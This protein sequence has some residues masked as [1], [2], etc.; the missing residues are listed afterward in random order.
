M[1]PCKLVEVDTHEG[2]VYVEALDALF[3]TSVPVGG[4]GSMILR[5]S[6]RDRT[7]ERLDT[8]AVRPNGMTLDAGGRLVVCEQ[9]D[10]SNDACIS[11]I[12]PTTL[13][14][15]VLVDRWQ[16]RRLNSPN[17]VA[18][19]AGG[20]IWFTDPSY[21]FLQGFRPTP[22]LDDRV[23]RY[24]PGNG[25]VE[26]VADGFDKPN[27]IALA[28]DGSTLYVADSGADR[29]T[30]EFD[31]ARRHQVVAYDITS[32]NRLSGR[33]VF[34]VIERGAPDGL[35]VDVSGRVYVSSPAGVLVYAPD[36][37]LVG[38]IDVP[39]AVNFCFGRYGGNDVLFITADTAVWVA[40]CHGNGEPQ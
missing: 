37:S 10:L 32:A 22:Q 28:P 16:G 25:L 23:Y 40:A 12:D 13:V 3:A 33:R 38:T 17:D 5:I 19:D 26:P 31:S 34:A 39:H 9:G 2:P 21:G 8:G 35:K 4:Q 6:L 18:V 20:A 7:V 29:G 1:K 15:D 11:R 36:G 14:R 24:D 30:G 27:G